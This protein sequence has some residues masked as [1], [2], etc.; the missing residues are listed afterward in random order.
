MLSSLKVVALYVRTGSQTYWI[1]RGVVP[2]DTEP[3]TGFAMK[4]APRNV[5]VKAV[6]LYLLSGSVHRMRSRRKRNRLAV[7]S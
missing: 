6:L 1:W 5:N 3:D 2:F 4:A 7:D